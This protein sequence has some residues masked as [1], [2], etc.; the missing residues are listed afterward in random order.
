MLAFPSDEGMSKIHAKIK[1]S[2]T[3]GVVFVRDVSK[4]GTSVGR[5]Q[6]RKSEDWHRVEDGAIPSAW[7]AMS[8]SSPMTPRF[9]VWWESLW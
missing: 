4:N 1:V 5:Q 2:E 7:F 6:L 8:R 9:L 3:D